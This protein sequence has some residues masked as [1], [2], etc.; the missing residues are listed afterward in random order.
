MTIEKYLKNT[1]LNKKVFNGRLMA[2]MIFSLILAIV[3]FWWLKLI[4]ITK[5]GEA[6]CGMME[7]VHDETCI[8]CEIEEHIHDASC[9]SNL[10]ADLETAKDWEA[11]M[12]N[13]NFRPYALDNVLSVA[14]SQLGYEES[15][16]NF[17]IIDGTTLRNGYTR[18][19]QW[20]GNPYGNWSTMFVSF[21]LHYA[22]IKD[23]PLASGAQT[24]QIK[25]ESAGLYEDVSSYIPVSGDVVFLDADYDG[26]ID[27]TAIVSAVSDTEISV[28]QG[29]LDHKVAQTVYSFDSG[30]VHGYGIPSLAAKL[31]V[32]GNIYQP[33]ATFSAAMDASAAIAQ[34]VTYS[35][36]IFNSDSSFV[37][38]TIGTNG[39]YYA[40]DG[41][42]SAV[43]IFIDGNGN[44]TSD[45]GDP[46]RILWRFEYCGTENNSPTYYIRNVATG[47]Y[48]HPYYDNANSHGAVLTGRWESALI[49]NGGGVKIK[50]A[51]QA[52]GYGRLV[53]NSS[54]TDSPSSNGSTFYFA[55]T[56]TQYAIWLD[57]TN[58]GLRSL[59]GTPDTAYFVNEGDVVTLPSQ[60]RSPTK[61][62]YSLRGWY[63]VAN[64]KYYAPGAEITVTEHMVFYADWQAATYDVGQYND[65]I[66]NTVSTS[67]YIT[68]KV[69][70]FGPLFNALSA[71]ATVNVSASGHSETWSIVQNG[72]LSNGQASLNYIFVDYDAGGDISY[73]NNRGT[74]NNSQDTSTVGLY[75]PALAQILF[76]TDNLFDPL[77][78]KGVLGK[79]YLGEGDYLFQFDDNPNSELYGYYYYD[80]KLNAAS[81]N[82]SE[83]RFYVYNYLSRTADTAR[84]GGNAGYSDFLPFNSPYANTNGQS[85]A[86]YTYRG[87][88]GEFPSGT[89]HYQYDSAHSGGNNSENNVNTNYWFGISMDV[90]FYLS[91]EIGNGGNKDVFGNEMHFHFAGDDDVWILIDGVLVLDIGGIHDIKDGDINFTT[92][93]ITR[94]NQVIGNLSDYGIAPG[95]HIL[96]VYYLERGASKSNCQF[97]FNL[98][99][100]FDFE[101][102]KEDVLTMEE[103]D[104]AE[105]SVYMDKACTIPAQLWVSEEAYNSGLP[106]TNIFRV[107]DGYAHMWGLTTGYSYFIKE[108]KPPD[109]PN[110]SM[111]HGIICLTLAQQGLATY[112]IEILEDG[113]DGISPGYTVHNFSVDVKTLKAYCTV[114]NAQDWVRE[115]T[116]VDIFKE[117]DDDKDHQSDLPTFYLLV[118]GQDGIFRRIREIKLGADNGWEYTWTNLPKYYVDAQGN[119]VEA[120][121]YRVEEAYYAGYVPTIEKVDKIA[122]G[123]KVWA[124]A[125]SFQNGE[126]YVLKTMYGCLATQTSTSS[127]LVWVDE[128]TA[129]T[130]PLALWTAT[131]NQDGTVVFKN[132][133]GRI[134]QFSYR[135]GSV[136][137]SNFITTTGTTNTKMQYEQADGQGI[138]IYYTNNNIKYY[139]GSTVNQTGIAA[140]EQ[141]NGVVITPLVEKEEEIIVE[142][143]TFVYRVINTPID[144]SNQVSVTIHKK[145]ELGIINSQAYLTYQIPISLYANG[146][147]SGRYALLTLQNGWTVTFEGLP[148]KDD[149][150]NVIK[151]SVL[152]HWNEVGWEIFYGDMHYTEGAPGKYTTTITNRNRAGHGYELPATGGQGGAPFVFF[153]GAIMC[154]TVICGYVLRRKRERREQ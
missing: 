137:S 90:K 144:V 109:K 113:E 133:S 100:R 75:N 50:G 83:G 4:G 55:K 91:D 87:D 70:D 145:W 104:G 114:T 8:E 3:V 38:Y 124:E 54:F 34:T 42:G 154:T 134:L 103:L 150:G 10:K 67:K 56:P 13:V 12:K 78:G 48:L 22:G 148:Y 35:T 85:I 24:L 146:V 19:G 39:K 149:D 49:Q 121:E 68:T 135:T 6:F 88:N 107:K 79:N 138:R 21:C 95:E 111:A 129:K 102:R 36:S 98:S 7:H 116:S 74:A 51:R 18:Y 72:N 17:M 65:K 69:F 118:K 47:Y 106:S 97:Y 151:Y 63:D 153:G 115:I 29:D 28:I 105:F 44:V 86:T 31:S 77:T 76:G 23:V 84:D 11:T 136:T 2:V 62:E 14:Q 82:Q 5:A 96:T 147:D 99:P 112:T 126:V 60:W 30:A 57:G 33:I 59:Q 27:S 89:L 41:S 92:G 120:I 140:A 43:E 128:E 32:I 139:I 26:S 127:R 123:E 81:Y 66:I 152:E 122:T 61:Y 25:W 93:V 131:V 71:N 117:W 110:Y 40:I 130:S 16:L 58:G 45:I 142:N 64:R 125:Y 53:Y 101:L 141:A 37:V 132:Q 94:E 15:K 108:T 1:K 20:Y 9:Y 119:N 46:N 80:S 143:G 52:N 73:P